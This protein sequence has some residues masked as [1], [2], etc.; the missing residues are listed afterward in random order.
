MKSFLLTLF[1]VMFLSVP[2]FGQEPDTTNTVF[3]FSTTDMLA[4]PPDV[5]DL[6]VTTS[7]KN[8]ETLRD[9]TASISV[10]NAYEI[11]DYGA[12]TIRDVLDRVVSTYVTGSTFMPNNIVSIR[13]DVTNGFNTHVLVL[14]DGRPVRD[15][16]FNGFNSAVYSGIALSSIERIEVV[17]GPGSVLY[18]TSAF[19]GVIN[20]ILKKG[21]K[22]GVQASQSAGA[23]GTQLYEAGIGFEKGKLKMATNFRLFDTRGWDFSSYD[24]SKTLINEKVSNKASSANLNAQYGSFQLNV[25]WTQ[26]R[27]NVFSEGEFIKLEQYRQIQNTRFFTDLGFQKDITKWWTFNFNVTYNRS[28][29][30]EDIALTSSNTRGNYH[31][32]F[33]T[34]LIL[35]GYSQFKPIKNLNIMAGGLRNIIAGK[36]EQSH[37][38]PDGKLYDYT[39]APINPNPRISTPLYNDNWFSFYAQAD[40]TFWKNKMKI[41]AG[42]QYNL[43]NGKTSLVPRGGFVYKVNESWTSK[44]MYGQA[45][46]TGSGYERL[47]TEEEAFGNAN[48]NPENIKTLELNLAY[49]HPNK[50]VALSLTAYRSWSNDL[51]IL[52]NPDDSLYIY[53]FTGESIPIYINLQNLRHKGAELEGRFNLAK[54]LQLISA[55]SWQDVEMNKAIDDDHSGEPEEGHGTITQATG[56]PRFMLKTGL[57]YKNTQRG[58]SFGVFNS[59]YSKVKPINLHDADGHVHDEEPRN[60]NPNPHAYNYLSI[61]ASLDL[62]TVFNIENIPQTTLSIFV[63]NALNSQIYYA[64]YGRSEVNSIQGRGGRGIYGRL[65]VK[66]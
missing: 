54:R 46:R 13:G 6:K 60:Y 31:D 44:L 15:N 63:Q 5:T 50:K 33:S 30:Y 35:E 11:E 22:R 29:Y 25:L 24:H 27:D 14:L 19:A 57:L 65:A 28:H 18:G 26:A 8:A 21:K 3:K 39:L 32:A 49:T 48:L 64:E 7:S 53:P 52:S 59:F 55:F 62:R 17:R 41:L 37:R 4:L 51:I 9:A 2:V 12:L 47:S 10:I 43:A 58:I 42:A 45:F 36:F 23:F 38:T 34:D 61:N 66:F 56:I 40:Y 20:I 16:F 1:L